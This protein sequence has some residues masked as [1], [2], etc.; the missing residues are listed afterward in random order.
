[1]N[2]YTYIYKNNTPSNYF[3][4]DERIIGD[5]WYYVG[6]TYDDY[7]NGA[8]V[9]LTSEQISFHDEHPN[10]T[11][12]QVL[13]LEVPEPPKRTIE[14]AKSNKLRQITYYDNST[15]V[16]G[17]TINNSITAWF[18]PAERNNYCQ[19]VSAAKLMGVEMLSFFV[20][21]TELTVST[22]NAEMMLAAIQLYADKCYIVTMQHK[23]AVNNLESIEEVDN[24]D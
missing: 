16:N 10:A 7:L 21:N 2:T 9:E 11:I 19:S 5:S 23:L 4:T 3:T 18:T 24:Y 20:N 15:M 13:K 17:F 8:Y 14:E 6:T 1:M 12:E 22:A